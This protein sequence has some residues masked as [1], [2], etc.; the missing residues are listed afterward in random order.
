M[1]LLKGDIR[2]ELFTFPN[3]PKRPSK[4]EAIGLRHL[5]FEVT[6]LEPIIKKLNSFGVETEKI[7]VDPVTDARFT[8]FQDPDGPP[9]G[10]LRR[11]I[12]DV[13]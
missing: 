6:S 1:D 13:I 5:A 9:A 3:A 7:R 2:I 8:F 10:A 11:N 4:P 12:Q